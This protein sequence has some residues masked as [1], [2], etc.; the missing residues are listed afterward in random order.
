MKADLTG[1]LY[2]VGELVQFT[3]SAYDNPASRGVF[4]IVRQLPPEQTDQQ[5][6]V[7]SARDGHERVVRQANLTGWPIGAAG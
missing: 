6:R 3:P 4:K 7:R 5:Y 2:D 1:H